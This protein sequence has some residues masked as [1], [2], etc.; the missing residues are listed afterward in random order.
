MPTVV[1]MAR[2]KLSNTKNQATQT[3]ATAMQTKTEREEK[4]MSA[5]VNT[6]VILMSTMMGAFTQVMLNVTAA[7]A[8][9][10]AGAM[11]GEEAG[12]KVNEEIKQNLP[13]VDEKMK[14]MI[15]DLRKDIY[16]QMGQKRKEIEPLLS[17]P[18][19]EVGPK[20]IEKYDFKLP[21]LTQELD[22]AALAGYSQLL[23]SGD[24]RFAKMF[25]QLAKWINSLPKPPE[26]INEKMEKTASDTQ[27]KNQET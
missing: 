17:D 16:A 23:V 12:E 27:T 1:L 22:D 11:G 2:K 8:S 3:I 24:P 26:Q 7:M 20:I 18:V 13:E 5:M 21:K 15:S 14:A 10:M 9:G 19:F 25:M 4:I 6:S